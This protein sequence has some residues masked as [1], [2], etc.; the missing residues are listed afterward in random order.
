MVV[1]FGHEVRQVNDAHRGAE[2]WVPG[3]PL[4]VRICKA[5]HRN[6]EG[7]PGKLKPV[8]QLG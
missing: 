4:Q 5:P 6:D 3:R 7:A 8:D 1:V 2:P